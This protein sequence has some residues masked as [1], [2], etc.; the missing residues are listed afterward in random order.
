M[1]I[2]RISIVKPWPE[3]Y[4][5]NQQQRCNGYMVLTLAVLLCPNL[6]GLQ[7]STF[8]FMCSYDE[9]PIIFQRISV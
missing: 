9:F 2:F 8:F 4:F 5:L 3:I 6:L 7:N 1:L